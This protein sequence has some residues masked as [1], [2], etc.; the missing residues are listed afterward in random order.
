MTQPSDPASKTKRTKVPGQSSGASEDTSQDNKKLPEFVGS[1]V[2]RSKWVRK[3]IETTPLMEEAKIDASALPQITAPS[4]EGISIDVP[5]PSP[6]TPEEVGARFEEIVYEL[7]EREERPLGAPVEMGDEVVLDL[8]SYAGGELVPWSARESLRVRVTEELLVPGF[9]KK[10]VGTP[11]GG[12]KIIQLAA[13]PSLGLPEGSQ[14]Q[15]VFVVAVHAAAQLEERESHDPVL[16]A[17]FELG[18]DLDTILHHLA[19][20][21]VEERARDAVQTGLDLLFKELTKRAKIAALPDHVIDEE[22][23]Y[24]WRLSEG[25]FLMDSGLE[26]QDID[27]S[28][29]YWLEDKE[30]RRDARQR[31]QR[32][33]ILRAFADDADDQVDA[34]E[35]RAFAQSI[36]DSF[37]LDAS[38]WDDVLHDSVK[39]QDAMLHTYTTVLALSRILGQVDINFPF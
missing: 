33:L 2:M 10:L 26:R 39:E 30:I 38:L 29:S 14:A 22:I 36:A 25:Q 1:G 15:V 6:V 35:I 13:D 17:R 23:R 11:V 31:V 19:E 27:A 12:H 20:E 3:S 5:A 28:F 32:S 34:T 8:L 16:L 7:L 21:L 24:W 9:A 4:L 18:T 37:G